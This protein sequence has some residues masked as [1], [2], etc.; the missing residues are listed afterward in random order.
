MC[1][2]AS[3]IGTQQLVLAQDRV[4][5][6]AQER[7]NSLLQADFADDVIEFLNTK[8]TSVEL[9]DW[10][11]GVME[12]IYR[13]FLQQ[14]TGIAKLAENQLAFE[15]QEIPPSFIQS[16]YWDPP[17]EGTT[18]VSN[19]ENAPDRRGL[20]GSARL[21]QDIYRLDQYAFETDQRKLQLTKN[22]SLAQLDPF[23]FQQFRETGI[24]IVSTPMEL[25][26]RDFPGHY[27]RLI[28]RVRT[29][30]IALIPPLEGI[31]ATLSTTGISRVV[32]GG[33]LFQTTLVKHSPE[34]V[35]L[36]SPQ[37][38]TGLFELES[39]SQGAM[40]LPFE[41]L[42][43][44]AT[45]EFRL[46]KPSNM[47]DFNTIA[48]VL[49]TL[50]YTALNSYDYRQQVIQQLDRTTSAERP[51][52]FRN[53]FADAWYDLNNPDQTATPMVVRFQTRREDFPPN[54]SDL[55]IDHI[56]LYFV[57]KT[58]FTDEITVQHLHF[59]EQ[60][61]TSPVGGEAQSNTGIIST[62]QGN[63]GSWNAFIGKTP[64][65]QWELAFADD[66]GSILSD[67]RRIRDLF[68]EELIEDILFVITY[69]GQLPE[70]PA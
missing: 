15:R 38:A 60:D 61:N 35:A 12:G 29:S 53:Q 46:P 34:S 4:R 58:G 64:F 68:E 19:D 45:W 59:T 18:T 52:S 32:I 42:G 14:A 69:E 25:F 17:R 21:L 26:D 9:Y 5:I 3:R 11:S 48:D 22:I 1:Q 20:T 30:V 28:K 55:S 6:T 44:D 7:E 70:F 56:T 67:G 13:Y 50:E 24:L 65:G 63:A 16:D 39:Q 8:F 36:T 23:A 33:D 40:L 27:L 31:K 57:R 41:G 37:N 62:C 43:V 66:P 49:I 10:M 54:L 47:F 2:S 51:F